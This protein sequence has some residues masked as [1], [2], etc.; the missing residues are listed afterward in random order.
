[1]NNGY[2]EVLSIVYGATATEVQCGPKN[3]IKKP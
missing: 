1:M 2:E 3:Q